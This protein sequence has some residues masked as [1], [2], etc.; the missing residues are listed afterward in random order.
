VRRGLIFSTCYP[1]CFSLL[2]DLI[3][4]RE[5][6]RGHIEPEG[7]R[8]L[9]VDHRK[10]LKAHATAAVVTFRPAAPERREDA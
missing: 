4:S 3:S 9:Q 2:Y 6:R 7:L 10:V 1:A 5:E 8:G